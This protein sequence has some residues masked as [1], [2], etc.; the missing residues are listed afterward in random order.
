MSTLRKH[1]V[2]VVDE[3]S[4]TRL[5]LDYTLTSAGYKVSTARNNSKA[6]QSVSNELPDLILYSVGS[7][8]SDNTGPLKVLKDYFRLRKDIA[9][10]AEPPIV[11]LGELKEEESNIDSDSQPLEIAANIPK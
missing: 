1:K 7:S 9:Q 10:S 5:M 3:I 11:I 4:Y 8:D 6:M 2:L